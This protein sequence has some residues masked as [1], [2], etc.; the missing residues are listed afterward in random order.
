MEE[1]AGK[2]SITATIRATHPWSFSESKSL[3]NTVLSIGF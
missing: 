1:F 2:S 3:M